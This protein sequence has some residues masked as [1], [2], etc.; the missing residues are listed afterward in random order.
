M[1]ISIMLNVIYE[2]LSFFFRFSYI[3][4]K[5]GS[6]LRGHWHTRRQI[7]LSVFAA[8]PH[9]VFYTEVPPFGSKINHLWTKEATVNII[10]DLY[11]EA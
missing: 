10:A 4:T 8:R 5:F 11:L 2:N 9:M 7:L 1:P 3:W 6:N